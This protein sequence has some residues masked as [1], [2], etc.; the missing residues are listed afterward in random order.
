MYS[1]YLAEINHFGWVEINQVFSDSELVKFAENFGKVLTHP[2]GKKIDVLIP[3]KPEDAIFNTFSSRF[4][5]DRFPLHT[6][7]AFW[8][9]PTRYVLMTCVNG[10]N[11]PTTILPINQ[12]YNNFTTEDLNILRQAIYLVKTKRIAFYS[13]IEQNI[14]GEFCF[15]YDP[16][17]MKPMNIY[18]K[19][20]DNR[21]HEI[22]ESSFIKKIEWNS[23]K[24]IILDNWKTMHGRESTFEN[25]NRELKRIYIQKL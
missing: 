20:I 2:N 7:T 18:A 24:I 15:R 22:A 3:K 9:T 25:L 11:S 21:L 13:K 17:S 23:K 14:N 6:D 4:G 19:K 10:E 12:I 5:Y 1:D 16:S 8:L